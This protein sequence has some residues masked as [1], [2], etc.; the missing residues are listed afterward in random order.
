M[1][2]LFI[3]Q[4]FPGQFRHLAKYF[5]EQGN[6][7]IAVIGET[8]NMIV[9]EGIKGVRIHGYD[10]PIPYSQQSH[11]YIRG[12]ENHIRRGQVVA[13]KAMELQ[14]SGFEP[15]A[16]CVHT[17]W[18]EGLYLKDI[19]PKAKVVSFCEFYYNAEGADVNFDKSRPMSLDERLS[20]RTRNV[21]QLQ[22]FVSGDWGVSPTK[23]QKSQYPDVF[24]DKI[25][26]IHDGIDTDALA[27]N[28]EASCTFPRTGLKLKAGDELV[29]FVNRNLEPYRGWHIF[30]RALPL[31][32]KVRP[33]AH[34]LIVGEDG[35]SY[36]APPPKGTTYKEMFLRPVMNQLDMSKIHFLGRISRDLFTEVLQISGVHVYLTY[37]FVLSWSMLEAMSAGCLVVGSATPPV[38]EVITHGQNGLLV[39]FFSPEQIAKSI[40]DVFKH[41]DRMQGVRDAARK[42]VKDQYDLKTVCLPKHVELLT[43]LVEGR[44]PK[45]YNG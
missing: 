8:Q 22:S 32:Q 2:L 4:N 38:Q 21:T 5:S 45:L 7:E 12:F 16:I 14:K 19:F 31:I 17:G 27:P 39:D 28:P 18:G 42:T 15:D 24:K 36:G 35:V 29:T 20:L 44:T 33:N 37:P 13:R 30:A 9:W 34:I 11:H 3:H 43:D 1:K 41:P 25:S 6:H 23:W 26:V 10:G 40:D